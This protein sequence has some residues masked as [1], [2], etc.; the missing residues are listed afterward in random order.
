MFNYRKQTR[1][2]RRSSG[3]PRLVIDRLDTMAAN[4]ERR[5][6][7]VTKRRRLADDTAVTTLG[8]YLDEMDDARRRARDSISS[9]PGRPIGLEGWESWPMARASSSLRTGAY[10]PDRRDR[11]LGRRT[12]GLILLSPKPSVLAYG[13]RCSA[14]P[15]LEAPLASEVGQA[16]RGPDASR[17]TKATSSCAQDAR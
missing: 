15:V 1:T 5:L 17:W 9:A 12:A 4:A 10:R 16:A 8:G 13:G 3:D 7:H 14:A 11:R 2:D 6:L